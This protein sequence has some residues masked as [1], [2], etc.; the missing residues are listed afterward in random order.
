MVFC[1]GTSIE[2]CACTI[3]FLLYNSAFGRPFSYVQ[4]RV[5]GEGYLKFGLTSEAPFGEVVII[6]RSHLE[7][8]GTYHWISFGLMTC[9]GPLG[10]S[11]RTGEAM[12]PDVYVSTVHRGIDESKC[13]KGI[14][15]SL[16]EK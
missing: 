9:R 6:E 7:S 13:Q 11:D 12:S 1:F 10:G 4:K 16:D 3:N 5:Q 15:S 8:N 2:P 14:K